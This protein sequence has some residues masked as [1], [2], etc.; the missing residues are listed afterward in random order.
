MTFKSFVSHLQSAFNHGHESLPHLPPSLYKILATPS[1]PHT[2]KS[3][4]PRRRANATHAQTIFSSADRPTNCPATLSSTFPCVLLPRRGS[5]PVLLQSL[6]RMCQPIAPAQFFIC[7]S[8]EV[9]KDYIYLC[10]NSFDL[11]LIEKLVPLAVF[12]F[13]KK[14]NLWSKQ[15]RNYF[16]SF[17]IMWRTFQIRG[18]WNLY[19]KRFVDF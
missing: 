16:D 15:V 17:K 14:M 7:L 2:P 5:T 6:R 4:P 19:L 11:R 10:V 1:S 18:Y 12:S 8:S 13:Y 9:E 3:L